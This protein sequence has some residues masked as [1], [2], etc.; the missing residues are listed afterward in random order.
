MLQSPNKAATSQ[1]LR[2]GA[3]YL[4]ICQMFPWLPQVPIIFVHITVMLPKFLLVY[5][6][7][8]HKILDS[9][10]KNQTVNKVNH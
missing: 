5:S 3:A 1:L 9:V 2:I 7:S 6:T 4:L 8:D 10:G